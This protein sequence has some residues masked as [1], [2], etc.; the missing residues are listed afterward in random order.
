MNIQSD[1]E[2]KQ[3][4]KPY[5]VEL[6]V[7]DRID[8]FILQ[9]LAQLNISIPEVLANIDGSRDTN[10]TKLENIFNDKSEIEQ[11]VLDRLNYPL[12]DAVPSDNEVNA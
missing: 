1:I 7:N 9:R 10:I 8:H 6:K 2:N 4:F 5:S 3:K 11:A 12:I